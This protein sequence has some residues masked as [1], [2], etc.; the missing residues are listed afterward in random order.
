MVSIITATFNSQRFLR[1]TF[2]SIVN[3]SY[4]DWEWLVTDDGSSDGT[5]RLLEEFSKIDGRVK[6][7]RL[8]VNSGAAVAR[9][10][11]L[12]HASGDFIAFIDSDDVWD[13]DKL[14]RQIEFM[15]NGI[16]FSFTAY[17]LISEDGE[18]LGKTVDEQ[19]LESVDYEGL[20]RKKVTLGCSTVML[21]RAWCGVVQ[22]PLLRTGQDYATWLELL[23]DGREAFLLGTAL[24]SY[25]IVAGSISRNK[26]KK[27]ARQWQI[28]RRYQNLSLRVSI[29]CTSFYVW[30]A[31]FRK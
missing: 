25:R 2:E 26:I 5:V 11:S 23:K 6:V 9:N 8:P 10:M 24:S 21:R 27:V 3:Q 30:R 19:S 28:Y 7:F 20:L 16:D 13:C 18:P 14:E 15:G 22:M 4:N 12:S 1:A 31:V 29:I 17:R